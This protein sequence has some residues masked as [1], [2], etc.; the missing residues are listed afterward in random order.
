MLSVSIQIDVKYIPP[1]QKKFVVN[2][3]GLIAEI[4]V[5]VAIPTDWITAEMFW[6][7]CNENAIDFEWFKWIA[8]GIV[9][10][11]SKK[12]NSLYEAAKKLISV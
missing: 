7:A 11:L 8:F 2:C 6:A 10:A 5:L 12:V 9:V 1:P 3:T 4:L